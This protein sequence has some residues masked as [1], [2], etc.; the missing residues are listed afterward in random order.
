MPS[1]L[2]QPELALPLACAT[3][4]ERR[5]AALPARRRRSLHSLLGR[6]PLARVVQAARR[7]LLAYKVAV[8]LASYSNWA[9]EI[10]VSQLIGISRCLFPERC[11]GS[12]WFQTL[13]PM[14]LPRSN[15]NSTL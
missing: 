7:S 13:T 8:A 10:S 1:S 6:R 2:W 14:M 4:S 9:I 12:W 11:G 3:N 15:K 5:G